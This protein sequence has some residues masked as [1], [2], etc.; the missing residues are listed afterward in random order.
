MNKA[1]ETKRSFEVI[2]VALAKWKTLKD[3]KIQALHLTWNKGFMKLYREFEK[4]KDD[5]TIALLENF[6]S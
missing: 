6:N 4:S 3:C 2:K 5:K 1:Y